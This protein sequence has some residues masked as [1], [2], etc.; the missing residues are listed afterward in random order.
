MEGYICLMVL[1]AL[2]FGVPLIL[3]NRVSA[4]IFESDRWKVA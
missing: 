3:S 2:V 1:M 4:L